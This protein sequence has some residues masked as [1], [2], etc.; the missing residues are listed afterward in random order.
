MSKHIDR[1]A[2]TDWRNDTSTWKKNVILNQLLVPQRRVLHASVAD[3]E[4]VLLACLGCF[5]LRIGDFVIYLRFMKRFHRC[6]GN[7]CPYM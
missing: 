4:T 5:E 3:F 1:L 7:I 2:A 6:N